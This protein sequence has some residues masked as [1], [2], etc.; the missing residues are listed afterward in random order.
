MGARHLRPL[1]V[2]LTASRMLAAGRLHAEPP[3][4][5]VVGAIPPT[6]TLVRP[7]PVQHSTP[8]KPRKAGRKPAGLFKPQRI[9]YP[10]D[11]LRARFF[12]D[13]PWE[14]ARPRVL[15]ENDGKDG[16]RQDWSRIVQLGKGVDGESV[17]QRQRWLM[18]NQQMSAT[19]AYDVARKE[20]YDYR[21]REDVERRV[22]AEE[23]LAVGATFG[24]SYVEI[25][26]Q[27]ENEALQEWKRKAMEVL[28]LKRGRQAAFSG[29]DGEEEV[30]EAVEGVEGEAAV[31][32]AGAA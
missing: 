12:K 1:R 10:E 8:K 22:A 27:L 18:R 28:T 2:H 26:V 31:A 23:A 32:V 9:E 14:L 5:R 7:L 25:G 29:A 20:F 11:A 6:T 3:W 17:V 19:E 15:V 21:M 24:K 13:H 16:A 4:Y 30:V